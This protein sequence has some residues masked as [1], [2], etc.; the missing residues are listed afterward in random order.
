MTKYILCMFIL[1][2][3]SCATLK[4]HKQKDLLEMSLDAY[5]E[6]ILW[7]KYETAS[8]FIRED[9]TDDQVLDFRKH[10]KIKVTSYELIDSKVSEDKLQVYQAIEIMYYNVDNMIE[11][12][13]VDK[14]YWEY[15]I[16][17]KNWYLQSGFPDF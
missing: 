12:T 2:F 14:Q 5:K 15:D 9:W 13:L 16:E 4:E 6:A 10:K 7:G 1:L 17:K 3:V 11:K 8:K